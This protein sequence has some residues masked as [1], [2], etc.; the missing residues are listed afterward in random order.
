MAHVGLTIALLIS[1]GLLGCCAIASL[2]F[3]LSNKYKP[4]LVSSTCAGILAFIMWMIGTG[5]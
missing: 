5:L 2:A 3:W 1:G 4:L